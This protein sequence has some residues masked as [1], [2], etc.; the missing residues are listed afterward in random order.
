MAVKGSGVAQAPLAG[1]TGA[2]A[3]GCG[4]ASSAP[5]A[6]GELIGTQ[7]PLTHT[8]SDPGRILVHVLGAAGTGPSGTGGVVLVTGGIE[9][10]APAAVGAVAALV[11]SG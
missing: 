1:L 5:A 4:T 3:T 8:Q 11:T 9:V 10:G 6:S 7:P 2:G